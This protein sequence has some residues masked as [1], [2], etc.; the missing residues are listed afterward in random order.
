MERHPLMPKLRNLVLFVI[1]SIAAYGCINQ[2]NAL[3]R[4]IP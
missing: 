2:D 1:Q 3:K 4:T